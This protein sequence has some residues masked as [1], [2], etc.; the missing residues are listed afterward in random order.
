MNLV[1]GLG[2]PGREYEDT[3]H[4]AGFAVVDRV[5][6]RLGCAW[7]RSLR[8]RGR[9]AQG[10]CGATPVLLLKPETY[11]NVSGEAVAAVMRFRRLSAA[12]LVVVSD[13]ADLD[14]GRLRIRA[15]GSSGG[16]RG[17]DSIIRC[18]GT[19][20]F[21]RIR[22]GIGRRGERGD[23]AGHVLAPMGKAEREAIGPAVERAAEAVL[24]VVEQG[25]E[26]AMNRYNGCATGC[27]TGG[28]RDPAGEAET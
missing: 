11:M 20:A 26:S 10:V 4:N 8:F 9:T 12:D 16:H 1:V 13:D 23:L 5:A 17:L 2:N 28:R 21:A 14:A 3:P 7:R 24:W 27:E 6:N 18:V 19:D 22:V 15:R 25:A